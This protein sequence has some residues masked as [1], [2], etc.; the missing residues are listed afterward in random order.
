MALCIRSMYCIVI[1]AINVNNLF[2][3]NVYLLVYFPAGCPLHKHCKDS[4]S[5][6]MCWYSVSGSRV[7]HL[8]TIQV[9][10]FILAVILLLHQPCWDADHLPIKTG[11]WKPSKCATWPHPHS[12]NI[13]HKKISQLTGSA[14][15]F[16][17]SSS[18]KRN[19]WTWAEPHWK[20]SCSNHYSSH[21]YHRPQHTHLMG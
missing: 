13:I 10:T 2:K 19:S 9:E 21:G 5:S 20:Y 16:T 11:S 17:C 7:T 18:Q 4:I 12:V 15:S 14:S 6:C 8:A 1:T 3:A